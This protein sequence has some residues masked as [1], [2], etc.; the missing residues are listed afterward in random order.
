MHYNIVMKKDKKVKSLYIHIP[1]CDHICIYCDFYKM[2]S[3][4][5]DK[6][7][8]IKY[9]IK[10]LIKKK[11]IY[12][13]NYLETIYI[14][15]GTPSSIKLSL[16]EDLFKTIEN[17]IDITKIKEYSIECNP[18]DVTSE[19]VLLLSKYHINRVSLGVQSLNQEKL[20]F[21]GRN[22]NKNDVIN[23]I[24]LLQDNGIKNI[25]CDLIY[26]THFDNKKLLFDDIKE[27]ISLDIKHLS[28]YT[29]IIENK[30]ILSKF[31]KN[32]YTPL[33][34]DDEADLFNG[35]NDYLKENNLIH[36]EVSNYCLKGYES[37]HNLTYWNNEYYYG[38]GA[39]A[40]Y[41]FN[42]YRYTN[43]KNLKK[44]Y[45]YVDSLKENINAN[46]LI[47]EERNTV[48]DIQ[49]L[50]N[51]IMLGLRKTKGINIDEVNN[52]Y[53]IDLLD[54]FPK[55]NFLIKN[56]LLQIDYDE[57]EKVNYLSVLEKH[58]YTLNGIIVEI[59]GDYLL[60]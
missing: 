45:Q 16:L 3:K 15:G 1:F 5:N 27:L 12:D 29:L 22:H 32:G 55:I 20:F 14:G 9:L 42:D 21:L 28:C 59:L 19:L 39:G 23:A 25:S 47:F 46:D 17:E 13:Y 34:D 40:S 38:L 60:Q 26:G 7:I 33:S 44:Y 6:D 53:K 51:E 35:I 10:E 58:L 24:K 4:E 8:Y 41:Y 2:M 52:K 18:K 54:K 11:D 48:N 57:N 43:V 37:L 31:I 56:D 30:T 36:Y 50:T 49:S